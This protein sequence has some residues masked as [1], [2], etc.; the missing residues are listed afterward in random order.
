MELSGNKKLST[1]LRASL[2]GEIALFAAYLADE[3][4]DIADLSQDGVGA[5][6]RGRRIYD[7]FK[8]MNP[9][10]DPDFELC[11]DL[12]F[13]AKDADLALTP[14]TVITREVQ[15]EVFGRTIMKLVKL[16]PEDA[17]F[18]LGALPDELLE[19]VAVYD[20]SA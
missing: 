7:V 11:T 5:D 3:K 9:P 15:H 17:D 6:A 14:G 13:N 4:D 1:L 2:A 16:T 20:E 12:H 10:E 8:A 19:Q 18:L